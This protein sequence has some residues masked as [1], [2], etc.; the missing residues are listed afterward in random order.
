MPLKRLY[1]LQRAR[2]TATPLTLRPALGWRG[3]VLRAAFWLGVLA[4]TFAAGSWQGEQRGRTQAQ[5]QAARQLAALEAGQT[6][7][8]A[9]A[10]TASGVQQQLEVSEAARKA[11]AAELA[12]VE[13]QLAA[14][15]QRLAFFDTLLTRND[16]N[17]PAELVRCDFEPQGDGRWR[18]R[19][20]ATQGA[21]R[22]TAFAGQLLPSAVV[23]EGNARRRIDLAAA[24][25]AFRHY[26]STEGELALPAAARVE[27]IELR[28]VAGKDKQPLASCNNQEG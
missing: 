16:R 3:R 21:G 23:R 11:L 18:W 22:D 12:G 1:R 20:L 15:Q 2:L 17:R 7:R 5:Q 8:I 9:L 26:G 14:Q 13:Q 6:Q 19:A 24:P 28:L 25:L 10:A 27:R 4:A